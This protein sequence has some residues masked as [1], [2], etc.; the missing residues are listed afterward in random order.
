MVKKLKILAVLLLIVSIAVGLEAYSVR[1]QKDIQK[2]ASTLLEYKNKDLLITGQ[3]SDSRN[4]RVMELIGSRVQDQIILIRGLDHKQVLIECPV[5]QIIMKT[6][7]QVYKENFLA[8]ERINNGEL[9]GDIV[10]ITGVCKDLK[11][12]KYELTMSKTHV[13]DYNNG[14]L[15]GAVLSLNKI[16]TCDPK[17]TGNFVIQANLKNENTNSKEIKNEKN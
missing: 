17:V 8:K 5:Q 14:V 4:V 3:C 6:I 12:N 2:K 10:H 9:K 1:K 15:N 11:D 16:V 13:I 7:S